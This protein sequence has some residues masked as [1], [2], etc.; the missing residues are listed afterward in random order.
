MNTD[1]C[2]SQ[3]HHTGACCYDDMVQSE[4]VQEALSKPEQ[5]P[6]KDCACQGLGP[7]QCATDENKEGAKGNRYGDLVYL[8]S[9][10]ACGGSCGCN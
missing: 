3:L 6:L 4:L 10:C 8:G 1:C 2:G 9:A 7:C 5:A